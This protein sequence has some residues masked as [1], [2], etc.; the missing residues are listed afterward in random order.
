VPYWSA[1]GFCG[2]SAVTHDEGTINGSDRSAS[3]GES[4]S[5]EGEDEQLEQADFQSQ[6]NVQGVSI[7]NDEP[8]SNDKDE[9]YRLHVRAGHLSFSKI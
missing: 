3:T 8:L 9:L 2:G 7:E 6:L 5:S 1:G 4:S